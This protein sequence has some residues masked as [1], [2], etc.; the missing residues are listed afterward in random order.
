MAL[1]KSLTQP[2]RQGQLTVGSGWRAYFAPFNQQLAVSV[3]ST[4]LG[5]TIYDL[6]VANKFIDSTNG[7]PAGWFDMGYVKNFKFT[8]QSKV[9]SVMTGYRGAIRAKYRAET[10]EKLSFVFMEMSRMALRISTGTQVFNALKSTAAASTTGPLSASGI[11]AVPIGASGYQ[12]SCSVAGAALGLP[13]LFVPAGSGAL[14]PANTMIVADKDYNG[15]DFGF[16]GDSGANLFQGATT[17]VDF[18]RK[19]SDYVQTVIQVLPSYVTG[20]DALLLKGP[21][22]GGGNAPQGTTA[23]TGPT[24]GAKVQ[25]ITGYVS[26]EGGTYISEWSGIFLLDTIDASQILFYYPRISPD[27]YSGLDANNLQNATALQTYESNSSYDAL[28]FDDPLDGET[29][30]R[31]GAYYP[32]PGKSGDLEWRVDPRPIAYINVVGPWCI[33]KY[34]C[35]KEATVWTKI[36]YLHRLM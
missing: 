22:V 34:R 23:N 7:P 2:L 10:G 20:Q 26:R 27:Q 18:I 6:Q 1:P 3:G 32:H 21:F 29:V 14:F 17:D 16:V 4:I 24:A 35:N 15:T 33:K 5:P 36:N 11:L 28:A 30:V 31:Y 12:A 25:A 13:V 8:P 19:T 9:G